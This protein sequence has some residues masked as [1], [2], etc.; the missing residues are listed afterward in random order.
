MNSTTA[1][2]TITSSSTWA[3]GLTRAV[4]S[5]RPRRRTESGTHAAVDGHGLSS[6]RQTVRGGSTLGR[7]VADRRQRLRQRYSAHV[8]QA[9]AAVLLREQMPAVVPGSL[10]GKANA[11][12]HGQWPKLVRYV[13][14]GTLAHLQTIPA[15]TR[16][17]R[18][19]RKKEGVAVCDDRRWRQRERQS[20]LAGRDLQGQRRRSVPVSRWLFRNSVG[21]DRRWTT[22]RYCVGYDNTS[23][24]G[25]VKD[26]L[27]LIT[28]AIE[29]KRLESFEFESP[30][31]PPGNNVE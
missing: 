1:W 10:L 26:C 24:R 29:G 19:Y 8:L 5:S 2:P 17:V 23:L 30:H 14:N 20:L 13:E 18:S 3:A 25:V 16:S 28:F 4:A 15:R 6:H 12:S 11:V 21:N 27:P 9:I 7:P 31:Q 22:L